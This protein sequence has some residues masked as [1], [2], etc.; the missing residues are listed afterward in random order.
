MKR[1]QSYLRQLKRQAMRRNK[2]RFGDRLQESIRTH[3]PMKG[4][5]FRMEKPPIDIRS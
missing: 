2:T 5:S 4:I 1:K 3:T